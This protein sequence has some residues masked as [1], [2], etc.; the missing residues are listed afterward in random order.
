MAFIKA[1]LQGYTFNPTEPVLFSLPAKYG[2]M[3]LI[4]LSDI[5]QK[6]YENYRPISKETTSKVKRSENQFQDN[7]ISTAKIKSD[8]KNRKKKLS[9]AKLQEVTTNTSCKTKLRSI[10]VSTEDRVSIWLTVI[11]IKRNCFFLEK[12]AFWDTI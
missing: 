6:E 10:E 2:G 12:E 4:I 11:P 8:I 1:L 5:W 3:G 9:D 7:C